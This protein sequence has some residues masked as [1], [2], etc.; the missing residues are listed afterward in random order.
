MTAD[1]HRSLFLMPQQPAVIWA[2]A[3][4][5]CTCA[6]FIR[7]VRPGAGALTTACALLQV[8]EGRG[9]STADDIAAAVHHVLC[10]IDAEATEQQLLA[11]AAPQPQ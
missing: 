11:A 1:S 5:H 4:G 9:L 6:P 2:P 10:I 8:E 7:L 3:M